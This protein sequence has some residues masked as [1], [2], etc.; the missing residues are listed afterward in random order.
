MVVIAALI[1]MGASPAGPDARS[2]NV[3]VVTAR[4]HSQPIE[5]AAA[6]N[7]SPGRSAG[8]TAQERDDGRRYEAAGA[9]FS[10]RYEGAADEAAARRIVEFLEQAY[11]DVG[12]TLGV[13]PSERTTVILYTRREFSTVT[14]SPDW[15]GAIYDGRIR[16]PAAGAD[17]HVEDLQRTLVHEYVHAVVASVAG[18]RA[19]AWLNEG[20]ATAL[21]PD[22]LEWTSRVL[23]SQAS[24]L[25]VE[26]LD[27][28]FGGLDPED[29]ALAYAQS[30]RAVKRLLDLR[31]A[32]AVTMLLQAL[33]RGTPFEAAFQQHVYMRAEDFF[34]LVARD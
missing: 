6:R 8:D 26:S 4:T 27:T 15:A 34:R 23:V 28:G 9:H 19:P 22:G 18:N 16:I 33:G 14:S 30:A 7:A 24:R 3:D 10:V 21:E 17:R 5:R 31:G 1:P 32:P 20:L 12:R 25:P 11:W 2:R 29:A 13:Y